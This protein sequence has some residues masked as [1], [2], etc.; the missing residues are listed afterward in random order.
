M[1]KYSARVLTRNGNMTVFT[2]AYTPYEARQ[3]FEDQYGRDNIMS[4]IND[5]DHFHYGG[6]RETYSCRIMDSRGYPITAF[7]EANSVWEAR[8]MFGAMYGSNV[9]GIPLKA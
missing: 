9:I 8:E 4:N 1:R 6:S 5:A 2:T 7:V 3:I